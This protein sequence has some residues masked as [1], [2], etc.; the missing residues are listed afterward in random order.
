MTK[1]FSFNNTLI[2]LD[3]SDFKSEKASKINRL[4]LLSCSCGNFVLTFLI[5]YLVERLVKIKKE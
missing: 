2:K 3:E 4:I 5:E 1:Y